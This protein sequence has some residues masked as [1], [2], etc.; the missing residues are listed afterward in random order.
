[1]SYLLFGMAASRSLKRSAYPF[2]I[3]MNLTADQP[4]LVSVRLHIR[5]YWIGPKPIFLAI[6]TL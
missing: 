5:I 3:L 6:G 1:M 4:N 2:P